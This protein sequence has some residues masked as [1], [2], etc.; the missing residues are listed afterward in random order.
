VRHCDDCTDRVQRRMREDKKRPERTA[1]VPC[2]CIDAQQPGRGADPRYP[3]GPPLML[4]PVALPGTGA[5]DGISD[6]FPLADPSG[7]DEIYGSAGDP[8]TDLSTKSRPD[9]RI[10]S[11]TSAGS[12]RFLNTSHFLGASPHDE[13]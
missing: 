9:H 12:P 4:S 8:A 13:N 1:S 10:L 7:R 3:L 11:T 5:L 6:P 2:H